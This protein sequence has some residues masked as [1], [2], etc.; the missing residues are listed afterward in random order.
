M[1][2][3]ELKHQLELAV[4]LMGVDPAPLKIGIAGDLVDTATR[5]GIF[6]G[7]DPGREF[8]IGLGIV[9]RKQWLELTD[10]SLILNKPNKDP[11]VIPYDAIYELNIP[12]EYSEQAEKEGWMYYNLLGESIFMY[13]DTGKEEKLQL[14]K[15]EA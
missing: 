13:L 10:D 8:S 12:L 6:N 3:I 11:V 7:K 5:C 14:A 15:V 9:S 2:N 4:E 1:N